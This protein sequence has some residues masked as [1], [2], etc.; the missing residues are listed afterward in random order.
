MSVASDIDMLQHAWEGTI[1]LNDSESRI[2]ILVF[3]CT[4]V[5]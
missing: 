5:G 1:E 2:V 3:R 4:R